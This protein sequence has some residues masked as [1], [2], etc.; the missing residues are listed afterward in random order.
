MLPDVA[1]LMFVAATSI[2]CANWLEI[3]S[4]LLLGT[5]ATLSK[6]CSI[7]TFGIVSNVVICELSLR[8]LWIPVQYFVRY[9]RD[10]KILARIVRTLFCFLQP[11][12]RTRKLLSSWMEASKEEAGF[13]FTRN[14]IAAFYLLI[15][16]HKFNYF[17]K[18]RTLRKRPA[19]LAGVTEGEPTHLE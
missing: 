8:L 15:T 6:T 14:L 4:N 11:F 10:E 18:L 7:T 2:I 3:K 19:V 5:N 9:L 13:I 17:T 1:S 12:E 16:L